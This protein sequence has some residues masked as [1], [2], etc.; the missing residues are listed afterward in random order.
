MRLF[1]HDVPLLFDCKS[2]DGFTPFYFFHVCDDEDIRRDAIHWYEWAHEMNKCYRDNRDNKSKVRLIKAGDVKLDAALQYEF[3]RSPQDF[4]FIQQVIALCGLRCP[5]ILNLV[6]NNI[7]AVMEANHIPLLK[8]LVSEGLITDI[9]KPDL[10]SLSIIGFLFE[11]GCSKDLACLLKD[12]DLYVLRRELSNFVCQW[13]VAVVVGRV[14][15]NQALT[16]HLGS[17]DSFLA[18]EIRRQDARSIRELI[19]IWMFKSEETQLGTVPAEI[20]YNNIIEKNFSVSRKEP[21]VPR[22][23]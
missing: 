23:G 17:V 16:Q 5:D 13:S 12:K 1:E 9:E 21:L 19:K 2:T 18:N 10:I 15:V 14:S 6:K 8:C 3:Q 22:R 11:A 7:L 20:L 4:D